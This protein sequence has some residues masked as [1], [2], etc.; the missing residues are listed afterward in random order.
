MAVVDRHHHEDGYHQD[1]GDGDFIR[2]GH[3]LDVIKR[4]IE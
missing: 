2:G 1:S 4:A 3:R